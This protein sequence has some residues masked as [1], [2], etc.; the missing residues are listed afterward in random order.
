M[1]MKRDEW[2]AREEELLDTFY[3]NKPDMVNLPT[4]LQSSR[5]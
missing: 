1:K 4:A 2:T 5:D 3:V